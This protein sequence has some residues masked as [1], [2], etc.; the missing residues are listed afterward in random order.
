MA[1]STKGS[2]PYSLCLTS[3]LS[4]ASRQWLN[5]QT[6]CFID[7]KSKAAFANQKGIT[8]E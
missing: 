7:N 5:G 8:T 1:T 2:V 3:M 6:E 4:I